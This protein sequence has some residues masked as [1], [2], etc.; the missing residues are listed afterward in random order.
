MIKIQ[1]NYLLNYLLIYLILYK[2]NIFYII[3]KKILKKA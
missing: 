2:K 3:Y 1:K